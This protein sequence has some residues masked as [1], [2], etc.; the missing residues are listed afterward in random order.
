MSIEATLIRKF[1]KP[2]IRHIEHHFPM[3]LE[4][5]R[6]WLSMGKDK[7][8]PVMKPNQILGNFVELGAYI[9]TARKCRIMTSDFMKEYIAQY[10]KLIE[11]ASELVPEVMNHYAY[12]RR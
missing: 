3:L 10:K 6:S 9:D 7:S 12:N 5:A 11:E 2:E 1:D 8:E 4:S